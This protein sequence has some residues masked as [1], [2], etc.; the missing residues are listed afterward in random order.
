[1]IKHEH[2]YA[3]YGH[4]AEQWKN[5]NI[6]SKVYCD[7]ADEDE[8]AVYI[9]HKN[10]YY[11]FC[12][13][14]SLIGANKKINFERYFAVYLA[15][16][17]GVKACEIYINGLD[18]LEDDLVSE[19][20]KRFAVARVL[21]IGKNMCNFA[22]FRVT[23]ELLY[24]V[25]NRKIYT[26][27]PLCLIT[28]AKTE[29]STNEVINAVYKQRIQYKGFI[30]QDE[31]YRSPISKFSQTFL[32]FEFKFMVSSF[33]IL[34]IE[35]NIQDMEYNQYNMIEKRETVAVPASEPLEVELEVDV[36]VEEEL[37]LDNKSLEDLN[38]LLD[39]L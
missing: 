13:D 24:L 18:D 6:F 26:P 28:G 15:E 25:V 29:I 31:D 12:M 33:D 7:R 11:V 9:E 35:L 21:I 2:E 14:L 5:R 30:Y 8:I 38:S 23:T 32:W 39:Q 27:S 37:V 20:N 36:E 16:R 4:E 19:L 17:V 3:V 1:M 10:E 22:G 34:K